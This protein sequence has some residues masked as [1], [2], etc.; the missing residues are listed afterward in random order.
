VNKLKYTLSFGAL[1]LLSLR[2]SAQSKAETNGLNALKLNQFERALGQAE[3]AIKD[4]ATAK[5]PL[6]WFIKANALFELQRNEKYTVKNPS[7]LKDA[8]KSALKARNY[9][10]SGRYTRQ[11][12][13]V[14]RGLTEANKLRSGE[15][16]PGHSVV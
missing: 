2:V 8:V 3:N 1:L 12:M 5:S 13:P 14:L 7:A 4:E 11:F 16:L 9:D 15:V 6:A 10:K